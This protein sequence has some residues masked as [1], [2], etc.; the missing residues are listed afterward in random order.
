MRRVSFFLMAIS[1]LI[2]CQQEQSVQVESI[3]IDQNDLTL[4]EGQYTILTVTIL[5]KNATD[6]SVTWESTD[7]NI[8]EVYGDG[9]IVAK[10]AG[11]ARIIA[12]VGNIFD[13]ITVTVRRIEPAETIGAEQITSVGAVLKGNVHPRL[14]SS[15]QLKMG[16][17]YSTTSSFPNQNTITVEITRKESD[18]CSTSISGL[19]P[20]T[21]YYYRFWINQEGEHFY[22]ATLSFLTK[23]ISS[24]LWTLDADNISETTARIRAFLDLSN[25]K[26]TSLVFGFYWGESEDALDNCISMPPILGGVYSASLN[27]LS[28]DSQYWYRCFITIDSQTYL[29]EIKSFTTKDIRISIETLSATDILSDGATL[30]G[31]L[32]S[33][34]GES[35][36]IETGFLYTKQTSSNMTVD[37]LKE[38]GTKT[39]AIL[40]DDGSFSNENLCALSPNTTYYYVAVAAINDKEV[41]GKIESFTTAPLIVNVETMDPTAVTEFGATLNGKVVANK[42][43]WYREAY[44]YIVEGDYSSLTIQYGNTNIK[45]GAVLSA[46]MNSDESF[47]VSLSNLTFNTTY[48]YVA[49]TKGYWC[50]GREYCGNVIRFTTNDIGT[51]IETLPASDIGQNKATLKGQLFGDYASN[52]YYMIDSDYYSLSTLAATANTSPKDI[53]SAVSPKSIGSK[54]LAE[55]ICGLHPNTLYY[56]MFYTYVQDVR[57]WGGI[58]SFQT[59]SYQYKANAVDL[60]L[61]VKW[62]SLNLGA[63]NIEDYG[64][65]FFWGETTPRIATKQGVEYKWFDQIP[66]TEIKKYNTDSKYGTI[67]NLTVLTST[68]DAARAKLGQKWR[69]PTKEEWVELIE[70]CTWTQTTINGVEGIKVTSNIPGYTEKWIFLPNAGGGQILIPGIDYDV[71]RKLGGHLTYWSS[72]LNTNNPWAAFYMTNGKIDWIDRWALFPIR[73][74]TE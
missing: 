1:L 4:E 73:P 43:D 24:L 38:V 66:V 69:T 34:Y 7:E 63:Y 51:V 59:K 27:G 6:A 62:S 15:S 47:Y 20:N 29:G 3:T 52:A 61:S 42:K 57:L 19:Q 45:Y 39:Q 18:C 21:R 35:W 65:Y 14:A 60:G 53:K 23:P 28:W 2:C 22:G 13:Y 56:Y 30:R 54:P 50:G 5:P 64:A 31:V 71:N 72:S 11:I 17:Q 9:R 67:D 10:H 68:D 16:F 36:D 48:S 74:V 55:I 25:I 12:G 8:V 58:K 26:Y 37:R 32:T 49:F 44:F 40:N 41:Y 46:S 33:A 70:N